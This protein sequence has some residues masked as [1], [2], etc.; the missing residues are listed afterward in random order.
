MSGS[1]AQLVR[2]TLRRRVQSTAK[3]VCIARHEP[4]ERPVSDPDVAFYGDSLMPG[5]HSHAVVL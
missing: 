2:M 5:S 1:E 4:W 3:A